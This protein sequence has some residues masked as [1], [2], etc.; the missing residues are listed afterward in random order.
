MKDIL[1]DGQSAPTDLNVEQ[2]DYLPFGVCLINCDGFILKF[3]KTFEKLFQIIDKKKLY[4]WRDIFEINI[5]NKTYDFDITKIQDNVPIT[6]K[7]NS[8]K[9]INVSISKKEI[10]DEIN[11]TSKTIIY[12]TDL[13]AIIPDLDNYN[14]EFFYSKMIDEIEDYAIISL[15]NQ[16][17]IVNWNKGAKKIKGYDF[18]EIVGKN[19]SC[20]YTLD[21]QNNRLP[22][23]VLIDARKHGKSTFKGWRI[24]KDGTQFWGSITLTSIKDQSDNIIGFSKITKD[25]TSQKL[26]EDKVMAYA[27][28][29]EQQNRKLEEF[30]YV[31][32]HDL[33]DPLRK[34]QLFASILEKNLDNKETL[35]KTTQKITQSANRMS[36][37]IKD[38]LK[39]SVISNSDFD[40]SETN[41]NE[42]LKE[43]CE[44]LEVI[45]DEKQANIEIKNLPKITGIPIQL[46]QL[47]YNL[48]SNSLKFNNKIPNIL[49]SSEIYRPEKHKLSHSINPKKEYFIISIKDN[50]IGFEQQYADK[51]FKVF[52]RL[53]DK[54]SGSG[55]GLAL[56]KK[57]VE[58]HKGFIEVESEP[59]KGTT[60]RI[61]LPK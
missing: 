44:N 14:S 31:A 20:F 15:D 36:N 6:L 16:G 19:I 29:V 18:E 55:I 10:F 26:A 57:I 12:F 48:V 28:N 59:N 32:S 50:G 46:H 4:N 54:T 2:L 43:V 25:L 47:F 21:D 9:S 58:N 41:L 8:G 34:I 33:Q 5:F 37:L 42:T 22:E 30:A 7:L 13:S 60:F 40:K 39:Y 35:L 24:R 49:I 17:N 45:I 52:Q 51:I 1:N 11:F 3:N 56:C 23:K 27:Q 38:I 53:G 61:I